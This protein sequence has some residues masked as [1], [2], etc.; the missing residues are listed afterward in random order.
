MQYLLSV[1]TEGWR[2]CGSD[3]VG[4]AQGRLDPAEVVRTC[5][6]LGRVQDG[7]PSFVW[8][9]AGGFGTGY[10]PGS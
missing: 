4:F 5:S 8:K 9:D 2:T 1:P 3:L 10:S 6:V 7:I